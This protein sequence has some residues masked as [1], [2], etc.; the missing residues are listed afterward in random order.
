MQVFFTWL[1]GNWCGCHREV[2]LQPL[3]DNHGEFQSVP[4]FARFINQ[5]EVLRT[6]PLFVY[7]YLRD[8]ASHQF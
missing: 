8:K 5:K 7:N 3:D 1:F 2:A 6:A 4:Y